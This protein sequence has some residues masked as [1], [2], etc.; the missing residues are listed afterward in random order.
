MCTMA[1]RSMESM[2]KHTVFAEL[3]M[4]GPK[5][6]WLQEERH[7]IHI[8]SDWRLNNKECTVYLRCC[9]N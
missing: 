6:K 3:W 4:D 2:A 9:T 1:I 8:F 7:G 5:V